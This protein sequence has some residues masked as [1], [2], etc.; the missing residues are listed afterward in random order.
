MVLNKLGL[1]AVAEKNRPLLSAKHSR[2]SMDFAI[3]HL[4]WT[5]DD[6]KRVIYSH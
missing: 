1:K 5:V 4:D 6:W 3:A 2:E